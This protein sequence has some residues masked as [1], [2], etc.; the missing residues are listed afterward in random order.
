MTFPEK[1]KSTLEDIIDKMSLS[2]NSFVNNPDRDFIRKRKLTF[3]KIMQLILSMGSGCINHELLKFFEYDPSLPTLSAFYQQRSKLNS[4]AFP[5]LLKEFNSKFPL[6]FF[7]GKYYLLACDGSGF[8]IARD[9][10]DP[11]TFCK[12]SKA[13]ALG[14]NMVHATAL[15]DIFNKR[16]LDIIV[17]PVHKQNEYLALCNLM[18]QYSYGGSPIIIGDRGFAS[19]NVYAH[20]IENNIDFIIRSKD[21]NVMRMLGVSTLSDSMDITREFLL[22]RSNSAKKHRQPEKESQYRYIYKTTAFDYIDPNDKTDEYSLTLRIV[23][24]QIEN[25]EFINVITTL[26]KD[27]F[28]SEEIKECYLYRWGIETSFRDLKHTIGTE[29]FHSKKYKYVELEIF[30]RIILYNFCSIITLHVPIAVSNRKH[31]YQVNFSMAMKICFDFLRNY[32][33]TVI[34]VET[35][36][37]KYILPIKLERS[38]K[39]RK[40]CQPPISFSYRYA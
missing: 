31:N 3:Q 34:D 12:P 4:K 29:N 8:N 23:R 21:V 7:K 5:H 6:S 39:R 20:A 33:K 38:F 1:V 16:Y 25:G 15:Y 30:S 2:I 24:F 19:Y 10:D 26:S 11:L 35:L 22:T 18:D 37:R 28:S 32:Q 27:A 17:Q 40:R 14:F 13:S 36:I 9:P